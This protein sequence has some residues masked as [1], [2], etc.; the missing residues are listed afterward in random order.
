MGRAEQLLRSL[1]TWQPGEDL[2]PL[3]AQAVDL[4]GPSII[5]HLPTEPAAARDALENA[6]LDRLEN[7]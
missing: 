2:R 4:L 6:V 5:V 7:A 3:I 1:L